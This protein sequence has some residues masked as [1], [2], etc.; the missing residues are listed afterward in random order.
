[1]RGGTTEGQWTVT[2]NTADRG[3][4]NPGGGPGEGFGDGID[5]DSTTAPVTVSSNKVEND[6]GF[7][8]GIYGADGATVTG[9]TAE[10][11]V[12]GIY[13]S[14]GSVAANATNNAVFNNTAST[15]GNDGIL[16]DTTSADNTFTSNLLKHDV[17]WGAQDLS[18]GG[19]TA[20]S[21]NTWTGNVWAPTHD[22]T[23]LGVC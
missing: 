8:I 6:D 18:T 9:D 23:P 20:G 7:G 13:L 2:G 12:N 5:I 1:M 14:A 3:P 22:G 21:A 17:L 16:A 10:H 11:D 19:K 15:N 4:S